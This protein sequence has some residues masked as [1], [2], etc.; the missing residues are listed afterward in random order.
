MV[1]DALR[2]DH[3]ASLDQLEGALKYADLGRVYAQTMAVEA[4]RLE[5]AIHFSDHEWVVER[6]HQFDMAMVTRAEVRRLTAGAARFVP[7]AEGRHAHLLVV[8]AFVAGT[9]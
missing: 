7:V 4:L 2:A 9:V 8:Q 6:T 5:Q 3:L 1:L